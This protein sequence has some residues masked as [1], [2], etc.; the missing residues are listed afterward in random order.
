MRVP[1]DISG[2]KLARALTRHLGYTQTRQRGS[3]A[4]LTTQKDG[5][6]HIAIPMH[7]F[8]KIGTLNHILR[9][10]AEHHGSTRENLINQ[11][12]L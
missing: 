7:D 2:G 10:L 1:R 8:I 12:D 11:L 4:V 9:E 5:E 6:F 3:H